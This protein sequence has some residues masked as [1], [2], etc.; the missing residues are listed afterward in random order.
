LLSTAV[1]GWVLFVTGIHPEAA[2]DDILETFEEYGDV[3][4]IH[5]NLDRQTGFVKVISI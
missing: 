4:S 5:M 2:E 1:E 3:R